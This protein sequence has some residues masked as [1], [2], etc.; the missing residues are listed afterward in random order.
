MH[1][2]WVQK[3]GWP[4]RLLKAQ[5]PQI[6]TCAI[7]ASGSSDKRF[8]TVVPHPLVEHFNRCL[9]CFVEMPTGPCFP[10]IFPSTSSLYPTSSSHPPGPLGRFP[11][12]T[13]TMGR[14]DFLMIFATD[15]GYPSSSR[16]PC[17]PVVRFVV[18]R[19]HPHDRDVFF[20]DALTATFKGIIKIS[21]VP[22]WPSLSTRSAL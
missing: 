10:F 8:A 20:R 21:Q 14:Y 1:A 11:G 13:D 12:F 3:I 5:L 2:I 4:C 7:S 17:A 18:D 15:F 19:H 22:A 16:Y 9:L 6:R